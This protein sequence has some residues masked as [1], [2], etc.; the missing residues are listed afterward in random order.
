M[1]GASACIRETDTILRWIRL[2]QPRHGS[3]SARTVSYD[4]NLIRNYRDRANFQSSLVYGQNLAKLT[5]PR[6]ITAAL[7]DLNHAEITR[8]DIYIGYT[9]RII[10]LC[11]R[12]AG[13][14]L[15]CADPV[16]LGLEIHTMSVLALLQN[17]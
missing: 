8:L 15:L 17:V 14:P 4:G 2:P 11:A 6:L 3:F 16:A 1:D 10:K 5:N 12:I 13:L 7:S 9:E